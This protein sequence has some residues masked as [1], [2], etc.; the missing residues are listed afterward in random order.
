MDQCAC[1]C[2]LGTKNP[3]RTAAIAIAGRLQTS[4]FIAAACWCLL[5]IG[6]AADLF[7]PAAY[8]KL[9]EMVISS[10]TGLLHLAAILLSLGF[11]LN[12]L[13]GVF[14]LLPLPPLDGSS[15]PLLWLSAGSAAKYQMLS[16]SRL[17]ILSGLLAA[18]QI[19]PRIYQPFEFWLTTTRADNPHATAN[20][21]LLGKFT[22]L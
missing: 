10:Q 11:S 18:W 22:R 16:R 14:N 7:L 15:L 17:P 4:F 13:F 9:S 1:Q 3:P 5:R 8:P 20:R 19:L 21:L 2:C 12:L 6:L